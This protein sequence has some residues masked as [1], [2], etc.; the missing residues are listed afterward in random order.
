M[1]IVKISAI[2]CS[3]CLVMNKVWN[4]LKDNFDFEAIELDYDMDEEEV[5]KY[6]PGKNIPVFII[7]E[8]DEEKLRLTGE[9]GY[10][11]MVSRIKE[12]GELNEKNN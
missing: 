1:K 5:M 12:V 9:L 3:G 8:N 11:D 7:Y 4:K 10:D 6:N 2:W